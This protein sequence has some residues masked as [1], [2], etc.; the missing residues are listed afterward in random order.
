MISLLELLFLCPILVSIVYTC[1]ILNDYKKENTKEGSQ[2]FLDHGITSI[3]Y[4]LKTPNTLSYLI[5]IDLVAIFLYERLLTSPFYIDSINI[6]LFF[7]VM[8]SILKVVLVFATFLV[9]NISLYPISEIKHILEL[10][11]DNTNEI[12]K[13]FFKTMFLYGISCFMFDICVLYMID[14][15]LLILNILICPVIFYLGMGDALEHPKSN[16]NKNRFIKIYKTIESHI[17]NC[18]QFL[19]NKKFR[20]TVHNEAMKNI[21]LIFKAI[22]SLK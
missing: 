12:K 16:K 4:C 10:K 21:I 5:A 8:L 20:Q 18:F 9:L 19:L 6:L 1:K 7:T 2:I 3:N 11:D 14:I 15:K 17:I 13:T 22:G